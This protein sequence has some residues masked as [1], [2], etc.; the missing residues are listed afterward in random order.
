M[1]LTMHNPTISGS[2]LSRLLVRYY[3]APNHPCKLRIWRWLYRMTGRPQVI[4]KYA[5][6]ATLKLDYIDYVQSHILITG[7]YEPEVWDALARIATDDEV[8][9]DIGGHIGSVAVRA[10]ADTRVREVH[11]FEPNPT[12]AASLLNNL[13]LNPTLRIKHHPVALGDRDETRSLFPGSFGNIGTASLVTDTGVGGT[14]V[15]CTTADSVIAAGTIPPP[16]LIKLD[17][18]GFELEVLT[19]AAGLLASGLVKAI[20]FEAETDPTG[21]ILDRRISELLFNACYMIVAIPRPDGS[22]VSRENFLA[23]KVTPGR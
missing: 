4:V 7:F 21:N 5:D 14:L 1:V 20:A 22:R 11:T 16:T 23:T 6:T 9:W 8:V 13:A 18:E 3:L 10:A 12:T 2:L 15:R 17:V 19:G